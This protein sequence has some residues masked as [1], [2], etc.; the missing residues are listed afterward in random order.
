MDIRVEKRT[1]RN[2]GF[3]VVGL[4]LLY[5]VLNQTQHVAHIVRSITNILSPF[6]IGS[7]LAF[8]IN[9]PMRAFERRLKWI[10][11]ERLRRVVAMLIAVLLILMVL[12]VVIMLL[13]PQVS[14]T[15]QLFIPKLEAFA[16]NTGN[17][18]NKWLNENPEV[19]QWLSENTGFEGFDWSSITKTAADWLG[20][21][22][23]ELLG[24]AIAAI[25]SI[26]SGFMKAFIA[27]AFSIY[28]LFQKENLARQ[29]RR[30]VYAVF[31]E[32]VS[33]K[34]VR[35]FRLTNSTF[36][37]FLSGQCLEV[38]I[39]GMMFAVSM[40]IFGMPYIPLI[41]VLVAITAFIPV[42]GAWVGCIIGAFLI[43]VASPMQAV[44]FVVMFVV[45]QQIENNIIYPR[46]VGTS[47]GLSG[48]WVLIAVALGGELMG[49]V[50]MF[51]MI[52]VVSVLYT[53]IKE[54]T[55]K[56]LVDVPV[57]AAKLQPQPPELYSKFKE[58]RKQ[59]KEKKYLK[60]KKSKIENV[61]NEDE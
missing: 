46:V 4:I 38:C 8:I 48:M 11:K 52:P 34:I 7:V 5:W 50:G 37:N 27:I 6:I 26:T 29:G 13:I 35:V 22:L 60:I 17:S 55:N 39:L 33:D 32:H 36:S 56:R 59:N 16:T 54:V 41:S 42:V 51:L 19:T 43:F 14:E 30:I 10:K 24:R 1:I 49:V 47:I 25:S 9:V 28:A 40:A 44:W 12:A 58:K 21:G 23:T 61:N 31:P 45:L 20:N 2:V 3:A 53:I 18:I 57:D 15:V